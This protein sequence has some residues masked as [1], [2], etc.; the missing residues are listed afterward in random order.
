MT[1]KDMLIA[2][3]RTAL[4]C[5]GL[6]LAL[7][8]AISYAAQYPVFVPAAALVAAIFVTLLIFSDI[9]YALLN[10][11]IPAKTSSIRKDEQ[12][13][14]YWSFIAFDVACICAALAVTVV[15]LLRLADGGGGDN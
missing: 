4:L 13:K 12:P 10:G 9:R 14:L 15:V 6:G 2:I 5:G 11:L 7:Y 3:G 1:L 8:A